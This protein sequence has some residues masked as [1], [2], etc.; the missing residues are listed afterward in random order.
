M[1]ER[2]SE[3]IQG[4]YD[5]RVGRMFIWLTHRML[6]RSFAAVRLEKES[7]AIA[8]EL[9]RTDGGVML[10]INHPAWWDPIVLTQLRAHFFPLRPT[11]APMDA[12]ELRRF[13]IF[14]RLG[15]FGLEPD[16]PRSARLLLSETARRWAEAPRTLFF[17][18]PQG[19]F[20]DPR[21]AIEL[22]P[23]AAMV[24]AQHRGL[25]V[26][27]VAV[28]YSFWSDKK[29]EVLLRIR[30]VP[31]PAVPSA[32]NWLE[33]MSAIMEENGRQ[34]ASLSIAR[35]SSAFE[36]LIDGGKPSGPYALW[37]RLTGRG[38]SIESHRRRGE[39]DAGEAREAGDAVAAAKEGVRA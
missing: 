5:P 34:L 29:P 14:L 6:R 37:L 31:N 8:E 27:A 26:G 32:R 36:T 10:L 33:A 17:V 15:L 3:L 23:G 28:E 2:P 19:R 21:E 18:T 38:A 20:T 22:R 35:R 25:A 39:E 13:R 24:A 12:A 30:R 7:R 16:D 11:M 1:D 9:H 4:R